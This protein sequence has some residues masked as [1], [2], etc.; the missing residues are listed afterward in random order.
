[1]VEPKP[2]LSASS[3][4]SAYVLESCVNRIYSMRLKQV[5]EEKVASIP[6]ESLLNH[7]PSEIGE[8]R[9]GLVATVALMHLSRG[10]RSCIAMATSFLNRRSCTRLV[11]QSTRNRIRNRQDL[12]RIEMA[13]QSTFA[14]SFW[15]GS[16]ILFPL[17]LPL[18]T[19]PWAG[20]GFP[21]SS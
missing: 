5:L 4:S 11:S 3:S 12:R 17:K 13:P 8:H 21:P 1:V 16:F 10:G 15:M 2:S 14:A 6:R 7:L 9:P 20:N 18:P 19:D